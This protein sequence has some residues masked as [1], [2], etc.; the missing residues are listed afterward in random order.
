[1]PATVFYNRDANG[2]MI[3]SRV[4][5]NETATAEAPIEQAGTI[6]EV[7]PG[8]LVIEQPG[9]SDTPVRFVNNTTTN[10]VNEAG[11]P[12]APE[13]VKAGTPVRIFYTK[14]GDTLVASRVEVHQGNKSVLPAPPIN[15]NDT[16]TL[17]KVK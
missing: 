4:V 14:V 12:V 3:A 13:S 17:Q 1:V 5:L 6:T 15:G 16:T 7:S 9:A 8:I 2:N 11:Q 10:Y